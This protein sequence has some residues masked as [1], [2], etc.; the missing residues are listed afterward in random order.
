MLCDTL[1]ADRLPDF[2]SPIWIGLIWL[3]VGPYSDCPS[4]LLPKTR[5]CR[6]FLRQWNAYLLGR[7]GPCT[8]TSYLTRIEGG[9]KCAVAETD[10]IHWHQLNKVPSARIAVEKLLPAASRSHVE[11]PNLSWAC[12]SKGR[13]NTNL[14]AR[15][16]APA[17]NCAVGLP[18]RMTST[19]CDGDLVLTVPICTGVTHDRW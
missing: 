14:T 17:P 2:E 4:L 9:L 1:P 18:E 7:P 10:L 16:I 3:C 11:L 15:I 5:C 8:R 12:D 13:T 19:S 6:Q